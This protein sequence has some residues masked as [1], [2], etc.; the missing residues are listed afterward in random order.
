MR[1]IHEIYDKEL[2]IKEK[3]RKMSKQYNPP[4]P[5]PPQK[6][7]E[8]GHRDNHAYKD[9]LSNKANFYFSSL[10]RDKKCTTNLS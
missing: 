1:D 9:L 5:K 8:K 2:G 6:G 7:V 4:L 3:E 10:F